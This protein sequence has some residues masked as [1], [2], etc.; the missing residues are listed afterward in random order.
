MDLPYRPRAYRGVAIAHRSGDDSLAGTESSVNQVSVADPVLQYEACVI[1][2]PQ[3]KNFVA[4][5]R[6]C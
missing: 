4:P 2:N 3:V 6:V 5:H 1:L